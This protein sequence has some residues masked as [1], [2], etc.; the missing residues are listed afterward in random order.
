MHPSPICVDLSTSHSS[1]RGGQKVL[2]QCCFS[3]LNNSAKR[4]LLMNSQISQYFT[5]D[6]NVSLFQTSDQTAVREAVNA[7]CC[8]DTRNPQSTELTLTLTTVAVSV[9]TCFDD[10]LFGNSEYTA[11][12]AVVTFSLFQYFLV[13]CTSLYTTFYAR[14]I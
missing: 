11:T 13:T 6:L 1:Q 8:V 2:G 10:S 14:H 7:A 12:S 3:F 9:L 5:V 4:C